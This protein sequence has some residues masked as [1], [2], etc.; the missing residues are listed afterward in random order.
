MLQGVPAERGQNYGILASARDHRDAQ[1]YPVKASLG[2]VATAAM[3]LIRKQPKIDLSGVSFAS[4]ELSPHTFVKSS[5]ARAS[6][7]AVSD[8]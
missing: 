2:A 8:H 3:M 1:I 6:K 7:S 4:I 5:P